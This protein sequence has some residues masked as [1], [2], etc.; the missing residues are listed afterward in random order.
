M[1]LSDLQQW[2]LDEAKPFL[3]ELEEGVLAADRVLRH[4]PGKRLVIDG[5][6]RGQP[7]VAKLFFG[8]KKGAG[9]HE[10]TLSL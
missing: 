6:W 3:L 4:L 2:G 1:M 8:D 9:Q 5:T 7:V 10:Y